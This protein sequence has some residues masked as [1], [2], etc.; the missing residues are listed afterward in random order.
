MKKRM[1]FKIL[2]KNDIRV[3]N[4]RLQILSQV[5]SK[6]KVFSVQDILK[7]LTPSENIN[8]ATVYRFIALLKEK[9]VISEVI[10]IDDTQYFCVY[11]TEDY[12]QHLVCEKCH[13]VSCT[14]D[15]SELEVLRDYKSYDDF[16]IREISIL[17]RGICAKC[18]RKSALNER[19]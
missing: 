10:K 4:Q 15:F 6:Q 17:M 14:F 19:K 13:N 11:N 12:H 18:L 7:G 5:L 2:L 3:T 16:S 1:A 9:R 8:L